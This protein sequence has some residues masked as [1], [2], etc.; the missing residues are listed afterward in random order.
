M[1]E[2]AQELASS[3]KTERVFIRCVQ[4]NTSAPKYMFMILLT[5]SP[6]EETHFMKRFRDSLFQYK[7]QPL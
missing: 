1:G 6:E 2:M 7:R 3:G 4:I 5:S